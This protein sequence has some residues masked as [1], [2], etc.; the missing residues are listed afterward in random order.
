MPKFAP[1]RSSRLRR[2]VELKARVPSLEDARRCARHIATSSGVIQHQTDTYFPCPSGRLKLREIK[3]S[4]TELIW[5]LR[6]DV[7]ESRTSDYQICAVA[8]ADSLRQIL[9]SACGGI[10]TVVRKRREIFLW[11]NVRIH[12][13]E[14]ERHGNFVE[15][16][17][18]LGSDMDDSA[19][20]AKIC[21]LKKRFNIPLSA[22]I[23]MSYGDFI[24]HTTWGR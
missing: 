13:D 18:I 8:D 4:A 24:D 23:G 15:F 10:R 9:E 20:H 16:E 3:G 12:L 1:T 11:N 6:S 22:L 5:Y 14:V 7:E 19:G 17:A 21:E 2:N